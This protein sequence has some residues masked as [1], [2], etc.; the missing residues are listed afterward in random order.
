MDCRSERENQAR[1]LKSPPSNP[2]G[3]C[4][5]YWSACNCNAS[6]NSIGTKVKVGKAPRE[7]NERLALGLRSVRKL[8]SPRIHPMREPF[9]Y[10]PRVRFID[11]LRSLK[12]SH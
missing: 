6:G 5:Y 3:H 8:F 4:S 11:S 9:L 10:A 1:S 2:P 12:S 7:L